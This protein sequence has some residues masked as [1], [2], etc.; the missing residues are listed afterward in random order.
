MT[1]DVE[2]F[3]G[4][5]W[6]SQTH[7]VCLMDRNGKMIGKRKVAH[8]GADLSELCDWGAG[9]ARRFHPTRSAEDRC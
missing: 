3:V 5:G 7:A 4:C 8:G 2:W 1:E 6:A 9:C